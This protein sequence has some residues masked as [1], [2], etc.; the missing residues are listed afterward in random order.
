M[1]DGTYYFE[2]QCY[3]HEHTIRFV[4]DKGDKDW[5]PEIYVSIFLEGRGFFRRAWLAVKYIFGCKT[6]YGHFGN[7]VLDEDD[8]GKM[9]KM[10]QDYKTYLSEWKEKEN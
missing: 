1:L 8:L 5:A 4:L 9:E 3:F 10:I 7:W 2:C 6:R